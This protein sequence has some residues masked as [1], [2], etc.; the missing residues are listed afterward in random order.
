[1]TLVIDDDAFCFRRPAAA[2]LKGALRYTAVHAVWAGFLIIR[3]RLA[4]QIF[5]ERRADSPLR[6]RRR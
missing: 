5:R 3:P 1:M 4:V 6:R 2:R